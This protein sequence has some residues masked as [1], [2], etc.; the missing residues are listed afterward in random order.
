MRNTHRT[1]RLSITEHLLSEMDFRISVR[2]QAVQQ[3]NSWLRSECVAVGIDPDA[4][5]RSVRA[6]Y[7]RRI[8]AH[9]SFAAL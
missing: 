8:H 4:I 5:R 3:T 1:Q 7:A 9:D 6:R 2:E